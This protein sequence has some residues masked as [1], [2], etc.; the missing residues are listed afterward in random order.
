MKYLIL[1]SSVLLLCVSCGIIKISGGKT[2]FINKFQHTKADE[3]YSIATV[4]EQYKDIEFNFN[5]IYCNI[6]DEVFGTHSFGAKYHFTKRWKYFVAD[7]GIGLAITEIDRRNKW[8]ANSWLLGDVNAGFG[9]RK[10][11]QTWDGNTGNVELMYNLQHLSVPGRGD[12]G[13]N[14]DTISLGIEI[15]F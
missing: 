8:L 7:L 2:T 14:F 9:V 11:F 13:M 15:L 3:N 1:I 10:E 5:S 12:R 4:S 6:G